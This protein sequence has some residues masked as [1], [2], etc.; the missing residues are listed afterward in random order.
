MKKYYFGRYIFKNS[1]IHELN[2]LAKLLAVMMLIAASAVQGSPVRLLASVLILFSLTAAAKITPKEFWPSIRSFRFL[3][4]LTFFIQAFWTDGGN[5]IAVPTKE[6]IFASLLS[7]LRFALIIGYSAIFTITTTPADIARSLYF[8]IKP[9]KKIG[10][11]TKDAAISLLVAIRFIPLLFEEADK[12]I[13]AQKLR[14]AWPEK[15]GSWKNKFKFF[16]KA[17]S[18]IIPLFMRVVHYAEQISVTLHYRQNLEQVMAL[19]GCGK[20][21]VFFV[22]TA[23]ALACALYAL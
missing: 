3:L 13:T 15:N 7:A 21:E 16:T 20:A 1:F 9:F 8:F 17:E 19:S 14:G 6:M 22:F 18:F 4:I 2:P 23:T 10:V 5:F 11:N 12:I